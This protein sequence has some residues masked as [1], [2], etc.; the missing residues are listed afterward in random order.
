MKLQGNNLKI[1][2]NYDRKTAKQKEKKGNLII[3]FPSEAKIYPQLIR[4]HYKMRIKLEA[5]TTRPSHKQAQH[6]Q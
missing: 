2:R 6:T 4:A 3:I 1:Q 5:E